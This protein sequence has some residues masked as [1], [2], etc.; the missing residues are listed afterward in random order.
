MRQSDRAIENTLEFS[1]C[2]VEIRN[3]HWCGDLNGM[4]CAFPDMY[5][6][7]LNLSQG[8]NFAPPPHFKPSAT[9]VSFQIGDIAFILPHR[10]VQRNLAAGWRRALLCMFD[11]AWLD[12]L[13]PRAVAG[14]SGFV[15]PNG[16]GR[17][18][19]L[20]RNIYREMRQAA[21][22]GSAIMVESFANALAVELARGLAR[23]AEDGLRKGGLGPWRMR[24]LQERILSDSAAPS[25]SELAE[26]CGMSVRHLCR[27]F[28]AETGITLGQYID[29]AR[30]QHARTLLSQTRLPLN[31]I[32][33][34]L[35]FATST[36]FANAFQR[37]TGLKP[38]QIERPATLLLPR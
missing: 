32:A 14:G 35:G 38:R 24:R 28:K 30:A 36:S 12:N 15:A 21:D 7:E 16:L 17:I 11:R 4:R 10:I 26:R 18:E 37:A 33:N 23:P 5:M 22:F 25:L 1:H 19:W 9:P 34:R 2:R 3:Y 27:G 8:G 29:A 13:L 6:F 20:L 31:E